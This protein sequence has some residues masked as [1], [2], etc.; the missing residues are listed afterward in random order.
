MLDQEKIKDI[1][2]KTDE[3]FLKLLLSRLYKP[4]IKN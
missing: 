2:D 4:Q 3:K 1:A